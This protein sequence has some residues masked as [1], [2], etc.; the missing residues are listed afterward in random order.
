MKNTAWFLPVCLCASM[1][2]TL[3]VHAET[4]PKDILATTP[5]GDKVLLHPNGRWEFINA[6][7]AIEAKEIAQQFPE[8]QGC[9]SG[10]QGGF[11]GIGRCVPVGDKDYNR[12]SMSGKGR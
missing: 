3:T 10:M 4:V 7:K 1:C 8:N 11:L 12:G 6:K 2:F 5:A 9:P